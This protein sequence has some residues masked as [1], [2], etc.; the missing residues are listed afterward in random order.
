MMIELTFQHKHKCCVENLQ[1]TKSV[2][3]KLLHNYW[4]LT[5]KSVVYE[6]FTSI[7]T[8]YG[9]CAIIAVTIQLCLRSNGIQNGE[10]TAV[11]D[12]Q[13]IFF[14]ISSKIHIILIIFSWLWIVAV[15]YIPAKLV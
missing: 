6:A 7:Y 1:I 8:K 12:L 4:L 13:K 10:V 2:I 11:L 5:L 14:F 9:M 3:P 15:G